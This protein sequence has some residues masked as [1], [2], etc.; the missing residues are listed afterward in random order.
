MR[1]Y[2]HPALPPMRA[3]GSRGWLQL[4][5]AVRVL[6]IRGNGLDLEIVLCM[7]HVLPFLLQAQ[8]YVRRHKFSL[9][10]TLQAAAQ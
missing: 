4:I 9:H 7:T 2:P 8:E 10:S 6:I 5:D 3:P 1:T